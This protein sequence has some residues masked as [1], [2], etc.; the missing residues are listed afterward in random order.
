ML[1]APSWGAIN[2]C[3]NE[4]NIQKLAYKNNLLHT[5]NVNKKVTQFSNL[6]KP[7]ENDTAASGK[8]P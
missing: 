5:E 3:V 2:G 8:T 7:S 1:N 4:N 6:K